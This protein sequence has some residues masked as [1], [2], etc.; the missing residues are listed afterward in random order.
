MKMSWKT[1][2]AI[3][4]LVLIAVIAATAV[5]IYILKHAGP[6]EKIVIAIA[7][8]PLSAPVY[9]AQ[10]KGYF[11]REG[12]EVTLRTYELGK[13]A[14][15]AVAGGDAHFATVAETPIMY[16]GLEG[17]KIYV[18]ASIADSDRFAKIVA[19]RDRGIAGPCDLRGKRIGASIGTNAEFFLFTYL[20]FNRIE[21]DAVRVADVS[22]KKGISAVLNGSVDAV[23]TWRPYSTLLRERLGNSAA[24][25]SGEGIYSAIWS[26]VCAQG[27][28]ERSPE[29]IKKVLRALVRAQSFIMENPGASNRI[30]AGYLGSNGAALLGDINFD[31]RLGQTLLLALEDEARWAMRSGYT[32][33]TRVPNYLNYMYTKGLDEVKADSDTVIH[34]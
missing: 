27:F 14:L 25:L 32:K 11:A 18:V 34:K 7:A 31:V 22:P 3:V 30:V 28:A 4:S 19:R 17:R 8:L 24:V 6:P 26:V 1:G 15:E 13:D 2:T 23:V 10:S 29:T 9:V 16:A 33:K 21:R 12:L 20:V 5:R